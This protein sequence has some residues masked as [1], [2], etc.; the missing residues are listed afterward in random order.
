MSNKANS[1]NGRRGPFVY[2][3][4]WLTAKTKCSNRWSNDSTI[5]M[6]QGCFYKEFRGMFCTRGSSS[7]V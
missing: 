3:C 6:F 4:M 1:A 5:K 7:K 2:D